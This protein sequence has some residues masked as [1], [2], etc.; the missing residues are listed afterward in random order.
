MNKEKDKS[1]GEEI[2]ELACILYKKK[3]YNLDWHDC[4][5]LADQIVER[6]HSM[7]KSNIKTTDWLTRDMTKEQI[8]RE[9]QEAIMAADLELCYIER[10]GVS[11]LYPDYD[12][13]A[14]KMYG[15]GYRKQNAIIDEFVKRLKDTSMTKWDYHEAV[16]VD[17][18]DRVAAIM[19]GD[20]N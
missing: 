13:I 17:E 11:K 7:G 16:D 9:K 8:A 4:I 20:M 5:Y 6:I 14:E 15:I 18:I 1:I 19:K 2:Y 10:M 12:A 3:E